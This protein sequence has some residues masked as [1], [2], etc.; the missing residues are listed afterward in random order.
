[1]RSRSRG[2]Q[3]SRSA[4][5]GA[6]SARSVSDGGGRAVGGRAGN[7]LGGEQVEGR[8]A[9]L[10]VLNARRRR[11]HEVLVAEGR[12]PSPVLDRIAQRCVELRV[13]LR[14]VSISR[15][16]AAAATEAPQGVVARAD[17]LEES[18]L[19]QLVLPA[20][21]RVPL[22]V[23]ADRITDPHN[24]GSLIRSSAAAGVTGLV[25][26]RHRAVHITPAVTKA[27][28]G[29]VEHLRMAVV[30]GTAA[31]LSELSEAGV[32]TLGLDPAADV[33]VWE[34]SFAAE[35]LAVVLGAEG[36]GLSQLVS[37]RCDARAGI[38]QPG[39]GASSLNV[40]VAA[41]VA[42]FEIARQ[43]MVEHRAES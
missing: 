13:P 3:P 39:G 28:A 43:R 30:P 32:W 7:G 36:K 11:V 21:G 18:E 38:P 29:A 35:P 12:D 10:E 16:A 15:L 9:V 42:C 27:A 19:S 6:R 41:A 1:M 17:P 2:S 26:P 8:H 33:P 34:L 25:L 40:A 37:R 24:L 23:V 31:A 4:P 5:A 22:L 20:G 14:R